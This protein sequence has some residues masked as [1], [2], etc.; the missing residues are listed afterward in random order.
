MVL[1]PAQIS[2]E[3]PLGALV[4]YKKSQEADEISKNISINY[5]NS[6][7]HSNKEK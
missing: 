2:W 5:M 6:I 4:N 7:G 3:K 1:V